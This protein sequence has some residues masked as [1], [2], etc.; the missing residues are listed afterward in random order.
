MEPDKPRTP[1]SEI[2]IGVSPRLRNTPFETLGPSSAMGRVIALLTIILSLKLDKDAMVAAGARSSG[3]DKL[4]GSSGR[5]LPSSTVPGVSVPA[6]TP[7]LKR[8]SSPY[9]VMR[10]GLSPR[11]EGSGLATTAV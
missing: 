10:S 5:S 3:R 7:P 11:S 4:I 8:R 9:T 2:T 6:T 1:E